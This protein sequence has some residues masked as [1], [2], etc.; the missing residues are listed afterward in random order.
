MLGDTAPTAVCQTSFR[1]SVANV[2][3][4]Y[5]AAPGT[6]I[7][8]STS[9]P[10]TLIVGRAATT[11]TVAA[12]AHASLGAKTT[13]TATVQPPAGSSLT[14]T[15]RVTFTDSG[16]TIKGCRSKALAA[17][18]APCSVKYLGIKQ[19]RIAAHYSGDANFAPSASIT[20]HVLVQPQAPSG[21]VAVFMN[22]SF[23]FSLHATRIALLD[24]TGLSA[25]IHITVTCRGAGCPFAH[26][27][28]TVS[29]R[30]KCG[31]HARSGCV[32]APSFNLASIFHRA[33]LGVGTRVAVAVTH[34]GWVGKYYRFT[35]RKGHKPSIDVSCLAVNGTR[36]GVGCSAR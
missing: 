13:Y 35:I 2:T 26:R 20:S 5:S 16:K 6:V 3:A 7:S 4:V 21:F 9:S 24:A 23:K 31:E 8:G 11:V 1:A 32:A 27:A 17:H 10:T 19:H 33:H 12:S 14:P 29:A 34:R 22:W 28:I 36:P 25:G 30:G 18:K 15:G